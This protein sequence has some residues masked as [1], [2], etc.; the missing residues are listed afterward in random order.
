MVTW[1]FKGRGSSSARLQRVAEPVAVP[2]DRAEGALGAGTQFHLL[3]CVETDLGWHDAHGVADAGHDLDGVPHPRGVH[4][5]PRPAVT[6]VRYRMCSL[7]VQRVVIAVVTGVGYRGGCFA[8]VRLR[9]V[10]LQGI[11]FLSTPATGRLGCPPASER[12]RPGT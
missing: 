8:C 4:L 3:V 5:R 9:E 1:G 7:G 12:R 11:A 6:A 10:R 2:I